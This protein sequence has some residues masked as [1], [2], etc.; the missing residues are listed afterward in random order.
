M[1]CLD[2]HGLARI[3]ASL[4]QSYFSIDMRK[5]MSEYD[6]QIKE[7]LTITEAA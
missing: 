7:S 5:M 2:L 6:R 3:M 4:K 1:M